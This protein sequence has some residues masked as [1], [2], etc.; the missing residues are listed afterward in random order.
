MISMSSEYATDRDYEWDL[1]DMPEPDEP[2]YEYCAFCGWIDPDY[3][4]HEEGCP[5]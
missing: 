1:W 4:A 2:D 5:Q 3:Q